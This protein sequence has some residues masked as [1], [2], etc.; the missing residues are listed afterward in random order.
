ME[1]DGKIRLVIILEQITSTSSTNV[2]IR[3]KLYKVHIECREGIIVEDLNE[4]GIC[5]SRISVTLSQRVEPGKYLIV[6][7]TD[8]EDL[9]KEFMVVIYT[10]TPLPGVVYVCFFFFLNIYY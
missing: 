2:A 5:S 3:I 9:E 8:R 1:D 4:E 10:P 7:H 6:P